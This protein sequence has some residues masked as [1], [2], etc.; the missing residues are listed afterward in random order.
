MNG[1]KKKKSEGILNRIYGKRNKLNNKLAI[2]KYQDKTKES[3]FAMK[4]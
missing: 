4:K 2:H 1:I 3:K